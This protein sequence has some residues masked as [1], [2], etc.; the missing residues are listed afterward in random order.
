PSTEPVKWTG[1]EEIASKIEEVR[2]V[3]TFINHGL[4]VGDKVMLEDFKS[5]INPSTE[6]VKWTGP[7]EISKVFMYGTIEIMH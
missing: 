1:P 7:F 5:R 6:P 4:K 2:V 3:D